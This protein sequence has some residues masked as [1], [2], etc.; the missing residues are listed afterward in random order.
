MKKYVLIFNQNLVNNLDLL[1][2]KIEAEGFDIV[3]NYNLGAMIG[4]G[5]NNAIEKLKKFKEIKSI[6][7]YQF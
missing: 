6:T 4:Y 3:S 5:D 1:E 7:K 2:N